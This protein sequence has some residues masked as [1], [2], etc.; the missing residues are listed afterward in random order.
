[1]GPNLYRD[2]LIIFCIS[3][4]VVLLLKRIH[5][6]VMVGFIV[7]GALIGPQGWGLI[8]DST[9][10]DLLAELGLALLLFSVGLEFSLSA[11]NH[12][13]HRG[14]LAAL[15]QITLTFFAGWF[16]GYV[17]H[18]EV[19]RSIYFGCVLSLSSSA[20][21]MTVLLNRRMFESISG[22]LSTTILV[23]QDLAFIPMF[24]LL[25]LLAFKGGDVSSLWQELY[26]KFY[27][28][29][30]LLIFA[31]VG[32]F[33]MGRLLRFIT[34]WGQREMFVI[35]VMLIGLGLA[36]ITKEMGLSFA[37]GSFMG[38]MLIG[39]TEYKF[40]AL[41]EIT[42]FR[43]CFNSLFFVSI[44]MLLNFSFIRD[45]AGVILLLLV[46]IPLLKSLIMVFIAWIIRL[47]LR[48]GLVT[49][50]SLAQ[51]GE[52]SFLLVHSGY[53]SDL[54]GTY[55]HDLIIATAVINMILTPLMIAKSHRVARLVDRFFS[56]F[57]KSSKDVAM[58][59]VFE[60]KFNRHVI[61]CGFG[62]LGETLGRLLKKKRIPYVVLELNPRT[63]QKI[64]KLDVE[65]F[66]GDGT[67][68]EILFKIGIDRA[69][70]L[71]ITVPG[72]LDNI[73]ILKQA[74]LLN[75]NIQIITRA[76]YR[77]DVE[78][79]YEAGADVVISEELE[80]GVEMGRYALKMVGV[81]A[82]EAEEY[83]NQIR[84][85]GSADFF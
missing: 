24:V 63:I 53:K 46:L 28:L 76:K 66:F 75:P 80:G 9:Q 21:V 26:S 73:S 19:T 38:G 23:V 16:I 64:Q 65:A 52:F 74:K 79:L 57:K 6:P 67:S 42:P 30:I 22:Q 54:I 56:R 82:D 33:I 55:L 34:L 35:T 29:L 15:L 62:P 8:S 44:G 70:L 43:H 1:M 71:A 51:I 69:K 41:S 14:L 39:F 32:R 18:W 27:A 12:M 2:I 11:L 58:N 36:W 83:V 17:L 49:G 13:K 72:F 10:I 61:V 40:Q 77:S 68:E 7:T 5:F 20:V 60:K 4:P 47:P 78:Q 31:L 81:D 59:L 3:I 50:I 48:V 45:H 37:L 84:E 25:P 85:Y